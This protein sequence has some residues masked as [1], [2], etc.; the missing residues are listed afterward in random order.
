M[1]C[2]FDKY[3][4][5]YSHIQIEYGNIPQNIVSPTKHCYESE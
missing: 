1:I 3:F 4:V 5:E 2:G